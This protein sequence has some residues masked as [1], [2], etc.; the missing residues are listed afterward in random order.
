MVLIYR[1]KVPV[2]GC[3]ISS[4]EEINL[5]QPIPHFLAH[6]LCQVH[7]LCN[8]LLRKSFFE[9]V[10]QPNELQILGVHMRNMVN[11]Q[12]CLISKTKTLCRPVFSG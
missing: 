3:H 11:Y 1:Q 7:M 2:R 12:I 4:T 9:C 6:H 8:N 5:E 10:V